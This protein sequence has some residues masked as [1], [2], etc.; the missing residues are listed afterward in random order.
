MFGLYQNLYMMEIKIQFNDYV[1]TFL[2]PLRKGNKYGVKYFVHRAHF[3][4]KKYSL[5]APVLRQKLNEHKMSTA[6]EV[7]DNELYF[8]V[9]KVSAV[10]FQDINLI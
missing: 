2:F 1:Q 9:Y 5:L 3:P 10:T 8:Y 6:N 4:I 7:K